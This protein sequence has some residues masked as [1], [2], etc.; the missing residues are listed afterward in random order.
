MGFDLLWSCLF[1]HFACCRLLLHPPVSNSKCF[2]SLYLSVQYLRICVPCLR[3]NV[4]V[5]ILWA[6][7]KKII[8]SDTKQPSLCVI[9]TPPWG[10]SSDNN[11]A[12]S[13]PA[14]IP[15]TQLSDFAQRVTGWIPFCPHNRNGTES[16]MG[17]R[18]GSRDSRS[19]FTVPLH[20]LWESYCCYKLQRL[21]GVTDAGEAS[22]G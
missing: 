22:L 12:L 11:L 18:R 4:T 8:C 19:T 5:L 20:W 1:L 16:S 9:A 6:S 3:S 17:M 2:C 15:L 7:S 21:S 14:A 10:L 13:Q